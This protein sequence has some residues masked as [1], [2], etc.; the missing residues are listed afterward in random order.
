MALFKDGVFTAHSGL[1]LD[2]KVDCDALTDDDLGCIARLVTQ[3]YDFRACYGIP[4]GGTRLASAILRRGT[5]NSHS[6][7][8][9]IVDDVYTSGASMRAMRDRIMSAAPPELA[10]FAQGFVLF[11]RDA[12]AMWVDAL[13]KQNQ[14]FNWRLP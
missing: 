11:A 5:L 1:T 14:T 12:P 4:R 3:R 6:T 9:L 13:W 10:L 7:T 8:I 2:W